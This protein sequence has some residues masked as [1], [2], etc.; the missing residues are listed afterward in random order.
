MN[1]FDRFNGRKMVVGTETWKYRITGSGGW[2]SIRSPAGGCYNVPATEVTGLS[3]NAIERGH[4]KKTPDGS[5][6]PK[7][8]RAYIDKIMAA[9]Q[10]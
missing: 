1:A 5:I 4:W 8:V 3:W 10:Q 6:T 7:Q 2:V 9:R